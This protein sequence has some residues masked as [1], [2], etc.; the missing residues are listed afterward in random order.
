MELSAKE[1]KIILDLVK[2]AWASGAVRSEEMGDDLK[3]L[4]VKCEALQAEE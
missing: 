1:R 4:K 3:A 2:L